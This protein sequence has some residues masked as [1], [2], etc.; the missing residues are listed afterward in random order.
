MAL[1]GDMHSGG[2]GHVLVDHVMNTPSNLGDRKIQRLR[3]R[4]DRT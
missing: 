3:Q 1:L 4:S 2:G